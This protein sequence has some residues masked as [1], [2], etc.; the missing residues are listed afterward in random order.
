M[1]ATWLTVSVTTRSRPGE[2]QTV[3]TNIQAIVYLS[4]M[5]AAALQS[6]VRQVR[7]PGYH[8]RVCVT[9][10]AHRCADTGTSGRPERN[11][12]QSTSYTSRLVRGHVFTRT[13][14]LEHTLT[15][16]SVRDGHVSVT[17]FRQEDERRFS[18]LADG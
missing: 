16:A 5:C 6:L 9:E 8:R 13:R 1:L 10:K 15:A 3:I 18:A 4:P 2:P 11:R 12:T 17:L 7:L 14:L